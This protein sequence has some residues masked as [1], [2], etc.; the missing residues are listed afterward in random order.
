MITISGHV[1]SGTT[2]YALH[3][4]IEYCKA[5]YNPNEQPN[6]WIYG[7]L[8]RKDIMNRIEALYPKENRRS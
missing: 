2:W 1:N 8:S 7:E 3:K 6:V 5:R 4:A